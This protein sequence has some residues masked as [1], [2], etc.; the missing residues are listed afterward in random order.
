MC[1]RDQPSNADMKSEGS[2]GRPGAGLVEGKD[3]ALT[4]ERQ[5]WTLPT[6][7]THSHTFTSS[8]ETRPLSLPTLQSLSSNCAAL[9]GAGR[10][11]ALREALQE[12]GSGHS[13]EQAAP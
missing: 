11:T 12:R 5:A 10:A 13:L 7:I 4:L 8:P 1:C 6:P 3:M 9:P 2:A